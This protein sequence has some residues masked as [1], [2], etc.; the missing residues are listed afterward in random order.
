[1]EEILNN[2]GINPVLLIAQIVNFLIILYILKR[3]AY[4]PILEV[5]KKRQNTIKEGLKQAE[6]SRILLEKT[7]SREKEVLKKAQEESRKILE[8]TKKQ[9]NEI[10]Q[11][12]E[13]TAKKQAERILEEAKKQIAFES[14]EAQKTL[15]TQISTL[16]LEFLQKSTAQIFSKEDQQK[17]ITNAISKIKK[18]AD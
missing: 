18:R 7:A 11:Q 1:M 10:L 15:S 3:F 16:A 6:E 13:I 9:R 14:K 17:I 12:A 8:E 5:L 2:F 4:K